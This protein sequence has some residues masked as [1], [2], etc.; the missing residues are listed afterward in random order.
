MFFTGSIPAVRGA[1]D[2]TCRS[3]IACATLALVLTGCE[4]RRSGSAPVIAASSPGTT[5]APVADKWLGKW[6]GPEGTFLQLSGGN[7]KYEVIIQ[8]LDGPRTFQ[9]NAA[10]NHIEFEGDGVADHGG[11]PEV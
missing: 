4:D 1:M 6:S 11:S 10:D 5:S 8:N 7:G 9:G 3:L 2:S